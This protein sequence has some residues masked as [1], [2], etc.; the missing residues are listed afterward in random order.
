MIAALRRLR[1]VQRDCQGVS[2]VE[3]ALVAPVLFGLVMGTLQL[4]I[5]VYI[6]AVLKGAI[7]E[8]G[9]D[10][11]L[12]SAQAGQQSIDDYVRAQVH[13]VLPSAK[14]TFSRKSYQTFSDVG[15]PEDFVD[16]NDNNVYDSDEC[17][18]DENANKI[19]DDGSFANQGGARDVVVYTGTVQ[20]EE[21]L[22]LHSL[23]GL[24]SHRELSATTALMNQ[25]FG[26]QQV[27]P[28]VQVCP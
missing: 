20:Y 25:P 16:A 23:L 5:D 11:G 26:T 19:W 24:G 9:R 14:V 2:A 21:L 12:E 10:S 27:H 22:P 28:A 17:F 8:A 13:A 6:N 1:A 15:K 7:Q 3:F 4:S 18:Y